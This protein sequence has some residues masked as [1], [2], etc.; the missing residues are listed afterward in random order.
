MINEDKALKIAQL[1][2]DKGGR[3]YYV[4]GLVRDRLMG[5]PCS[6]ID[7]E[8]H[9]IEP[10]DLFELLKGVGEPLSFGSSFG[11]YSLKGTNIDIA[12]P[13][14]EHATGRGH[15]DF[16]VFVDPYLS[17]KDSATRRDFTMN[18]V[19]EDILTGELIDPFGGKEDIEKGI[20]RHVNDLSFAEDPLRVLRAAQFKAR[21][22]FSV[23]DR[24]RR[25]CKLIDLSYLTKERV[26]GEM[27]KALLSSSRPSVFF[28][29]LKD[30][31][32]L[33]FWFKELEDCIGVEQDPLYH[34]E[35]DVFVHT[36]E[37]IDRA[38]AVR[39]KTSDPYAFML[40]AL[41]HDFGKTVTTERINGRIHAYGHETA[42]VPLA[43]SF[44]KRIS[45]EKAV[46]DY[47][48]NM[49]PLHMKPNLVA[50]SKSSIKSTNRMFDS[51]ASPKDLIYIAMADKPVMSGTDPFTGDSAF[52]FERYEIYLDTM[53]RPYVS[54]K[55]LVEAGLAP[56]ADFSDILAYAHKLRLA[57]VDKEHALKQVLAYAGKMH[58]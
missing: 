18:A 28:E 3:A 24:T 23:A 36:M 1:V 57:R 11:I 4:G 55:D 12:M 33:D 50:Y 31:D 44:V 6:D 25:L 37:V 48:V 2:A 21:F 56:S 38:A 19:M 32:Q 45:N 22:G 39:D 54:G 34:P 46:L 27:K 16:D 17:L 26:E 13:R 30:I 10:K 8:V 7:I 42:G 52:L 15:R 40:L 53:K 51:A 58:K 35:G 43:E 29:F 41:T 49:V 47:V 20:I 9:G 14:K 5:R